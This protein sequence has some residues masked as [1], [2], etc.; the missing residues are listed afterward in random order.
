VS[1]V[2]IS[3]TTRQPCATWQTWPPVLVGTQSRLQQFV[4]LAQAW[5]SSE[6]CPAPVVDAAV[7][8]PAV[9]PVAIVQS[10]EQQ[11]AAT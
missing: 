10:A 7:H 3:P 6:H 4:P 5:L 11:S 1:F 9:I 8:V 2:Q